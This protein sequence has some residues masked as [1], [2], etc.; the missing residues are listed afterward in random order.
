MSWLDVGED[1]WSDKKPCS[2]NLP[3]HHQ[4]PFAF[5]NLDVLADL[6][7]GSFVD[8]RAHAVARIFRRAD[9]QAHDS[10]GEPLEKQVI[11]RFVDNRSRTGGT[12]LSLE[13]C[14]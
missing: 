12:L 11:D 10:V 1:D 13:A 4:L 5:S 9:S 6:G 14:E 7:A 8:H 3:L 2:C